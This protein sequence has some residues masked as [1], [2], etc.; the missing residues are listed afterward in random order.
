MKKSFI[1]LRA[2]P[3]KNQA[4][5]LLELLIAAS[6]SSIVMVVLVGGFFMVSKNWQA[7]DQV[8]DK[9]ID[10]SLIRLEIEKAIMGAFP[11]TFTYQEKSNKKHIYFKGSEQEL[12]FV[13]TMSPS[14]NNQ[15]TIWILKKIPSGGLS[16]Q[17][18]SALTGNP[19]E[20]IGKLPISNKPTEVLLD[21]KIAFEYLQTTEKQENSW[22]NDWDGEEKKILPR[23]VRINFTMIGED[24]T[25]EKI[26]RVFAFI[27][28]NQHQTIKPAKKSGNTKNTGNL[29]KNE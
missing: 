2:K 1:G 25:D 9:A 11:Y 3:S 28:A 29:R 19:S 24:T 20:V 12:S 4:F 14:Y 15:L 6:L 21:Y 22:V 5:T 13:S 8:L 18:S 23:A 16:I 27:L 7:Q 17:I 26:E 10:N